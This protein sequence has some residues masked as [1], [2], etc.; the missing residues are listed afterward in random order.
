MAVVSMQ[1]GVVYIDKASVWQAYPNPAYSWKEA[2]IYWQVLIGPK[3]YMVI[4]EDEW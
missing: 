3:L 2:S 1:M 4:L